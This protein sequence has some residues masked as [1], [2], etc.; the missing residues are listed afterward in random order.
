MKIRDNL[1]PKQRLALS[2]L[3]F[4]KSL[5]LSGLMPKAVE[6]MKTA[7]K[8]LEEAKPATPGTEAS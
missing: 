3:R 8:E 4:I 6:A 1:P 7:V 2:H 5:V